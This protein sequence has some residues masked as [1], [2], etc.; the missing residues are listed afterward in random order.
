MNAPPPPASEKWH[1]LICNLDAL[2]VMWRMSL[3]EGSGKRLTE[4]AGKQGARYQ[5]IAKYRQ[6]TTTVVERSG[7]EK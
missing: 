1:I 3:E 5:T 7:G 2:A 4:L 6:V